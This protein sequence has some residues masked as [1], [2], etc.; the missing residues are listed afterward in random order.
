[1]TKLERVLPGLFSGVD[2][3]EVVGAVRS[4]AA[5]A[6]GAEAARLGSGSSGV[7]SIYFGSG[8]PTVSA[9]K[10]SLYLRT[11]GSS[12]STRLY[13]NTDGGTTWTNCTT[14]A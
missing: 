2:T 1:M 7:V 3:D 14:A 6:G 10:G 9:G 11:D 5:T 8:A 4:T 13:V 12:T